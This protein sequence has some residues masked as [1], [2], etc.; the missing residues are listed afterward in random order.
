LGVSDFAPTPP[1]PQG[2]GHTALYEYREVLSMC[3]FQLRLQLLTA[4]RINE[5]AKDKGGSF[6]SSEPVGWVGDGYY[7]VL[8][9]SSKFLCPDVLLGVV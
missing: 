4:E 9:I 3:T 5:G 8:E 6:I 7:I 2:E 1:H